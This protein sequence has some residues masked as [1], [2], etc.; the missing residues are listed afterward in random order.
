MWLNGIYSKVKRGQHWPDTFPSQHHPKQGDTIAIDFHARSRS[1]EKRLLA[2]SCLSVCPSI[3]MEQLGSH[4]TDFH[5][6]LYLSIFRKSVE[7]I[8]VSLNI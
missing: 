8:Q 6:I 3:C 2:S 5:E 4:W 7:K 1:F